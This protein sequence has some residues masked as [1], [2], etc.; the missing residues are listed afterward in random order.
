MRKNK[1]QM[2]IRPELILLLLLVII[3]LTFCVEKETLPVLEKLPTNVTVVFPPV[4]HDPDSTLD[5]PDDSISDIDGNIYRT[6]QFGTQIWMAEN[7]KTTRYNDGSPIL[8][9]TGGPVGSTDWFYISEGAYC[10]YENDANS[11]KNPYGA[12]YNWYSAGTGKLCP[13][14]WHIPDT[15]EWIKLIAFLGGKEWVYYQEPENTLL[16]WGSSNAK[17]IASGFIPVNTGLICGSLTGWGFVANGGIWWSANT[18]RANDGY[19]YGI[20][21]HSKGGELLYWKGSD[22]KKAGFSIR[23]LKD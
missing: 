13:T 11:F 3:G 14:G 19:A 17:L 21:L 12:I 6:V 22:P 23:C 20:S 15:T 7:L 9:V 10:W 16:E 2:K 1:S 5:L 8:F 4:S 18:D